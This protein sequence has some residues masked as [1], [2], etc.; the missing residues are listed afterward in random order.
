MASLLNC[1]G[2][3]VLECVG[4]RVRDVSI[5]RNEIQ[6]R[7]GKGELVRRVKIPQELHR[8]LKSHMEKVFEEHGKDMKS[9]WQGVYMPEIL[10]I[11]YPN[12]G[13]L[14]AWQYVFAAN[15]LSHDPRDHKIRRYH[16]DAREFQRALV[17]AALAA[18]IDKRISSHSLRTGCNARLLF[19]D[20]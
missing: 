16:I 12:A 10:Q 15:R 3:Q 14:L 2:M 1:T 4:L 5:V 19:R 18:G 13:K 8:T 7:D 17:N 20:S 6:V 9:N 11:E